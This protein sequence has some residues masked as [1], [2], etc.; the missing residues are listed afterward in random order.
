MGKTDG[1]SL[2]PLEHGEGGEKISRAGL[3]ACGPQP[4]PRKS[5][6]YKN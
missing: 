5:K 2:R 3:G 4:S 1:P 6:N